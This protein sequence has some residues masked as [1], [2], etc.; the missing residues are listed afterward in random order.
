MIKAD[1]AFYDKNS[2]LLTLIGK[3]EMIGFDDRVL[4]SKKL[5]INT[6]DK[7]VN[8][9]KV[10]LSGDDD[11]WIDASNAD[12]NGKRYKLFNSRISSCNKLDPDWTIEFE[13][14]DYY[15]D[16]NFVTMEGAKLRFYDTTV[17]Y[18]PY[19]ALPTLNERTT[20][21]LFPT[22]KI[23]DRDGFLYEQ[24]IFYAPSDRW[25]ME[26]NPQVRSKRG[27]GSYITTR[28]V[29]SNHSEGFVRVGY[30]LNDKDFVRRNDTNREHWGTE[31]FYKSIDFLP[32][33]GGFENYKSA[34]YFN[35]TY[36]NNREYLNLQKDSVSA[37]V[38]SNLIESR[39]NTFLYNEEN[40]FGLYGR[41]NIDTSKKDNYRT[42][43]DIPSLHYHHYMKQIVDSRIFYT[44]DARLHNYTRVEGSRATQLQVD[45]P[46][47]Y[48]N[49][50]F[51]DFL[52]LSLSENLYL[53][54]VD[55]RNLI[56]DDDED[57]YYYYRNYHTL[58][59]SSDLIKRY[60]DSLH[61][62][63]PSLT[64]IR[65][66]IERESPTVYR[67]L[68]DEKKE[69]FVTQTQEEQLSLALRQYYYSQDLDMSLFHS[70][71]YTSY[72]QRVESRGDFNNEM[73]YNGEQ[74]T[75]YSNLIYAWNE[76]QIRSLISSI[77]YNQNNYDIM[78]THF[79]NHDFLYD[80][81]KTSF[82]QS[83]FV[84]RYSDKNSWFVNFDYGL[85]QLYN[86]QWKVGWSHKQKCWSARVS[87]GQEVVPNVDNSFRNTALY[88][89]LNLN[90][91]GGIE[92][93]IEENFSSEGNK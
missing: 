52:D 72:P 81:K 73:G 7:S 38:S 47:I 57:Y 3:V 29:D 77:G 44:I 24:P 32:T 79:Y 16:K 65:P 85:E 17:L 9:E 19:L 63:S 27:V 88:L 45:V 64:Y 12:K 20:G 62:I 93:N 71:G 51:D 13:E 11:L 59:F 84:H 82:L 40:Y 80:N 67:D 34:F 35:G 28:F 56:L 18:L 78:L 33:D 41:Y 60:D 91:I 74:L 58:K 23:S 54:R 75:L 10:F 4:A 8:I 76:K 89:E 31:L 6:T 15:E 50:F 87:V 2:S 22:F 70:F 49:S 1:S 66:S 55:F 86:H 14:A 83:E 5:V 43:Q 46:F 53:S 69:L 36:L 30:F 25:D 37:L 61:N 26:F 92:Q 39:L 90:P 48:Y 42:I 68:K 21:L